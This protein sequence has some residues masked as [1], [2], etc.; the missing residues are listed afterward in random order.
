[1]L[2]SMFKLIR[3]LWH[4]ERFLIVCVFLIVCR[5][6][7]SLSALLS[8]VLL[9]LIDRPLGPGAEPPHQGPV[10]GPGG[11]VCCHGSAAGICGS[12]VPQP[13]P[14]RCAFLLH[15]TNQV[16]CVCL[17]GNVVIIC[18]K[19]FGSRKFH[20]PIGGKKC[21]HSTRQS[22]FLLLLIYS[23]IT[24]SLRVNLDMGKSAYGWMIMKDENIP[25]TVVRT[26]T[27][28]EEL[29]R[30]V[31]LLTDKTGRCSVVTEDNFC[32][33]FTFT[34]FSYLSNGIVFQH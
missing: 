19:F 28:P 16:F 31:Y 15:Y 34:W 11:P 24:C 27:I 6:K 33:C 5:I 18:W 1:M 26:S 25:G 8:S 32:I 13:F 30:L 2:L 3:W 17:N 4:D 12:M 10:P 21:K 22:L 9:V 20:L 29:G 14:I 23:F 7:I